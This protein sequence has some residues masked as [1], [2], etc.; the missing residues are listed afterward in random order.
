[1]N[2]FL[3]ALV[4][5][6]G[7]LFFSPQ[8]V[9]TGFNA[10]VAPSLS[11]TTNNGQS[12][13]VST[14]TVAVSLGSAPTVG[15]TIVVAAYQFSNSGPTCVD[16]AVPPNTYMAGSPGII[17]TG[18]LFGS[19]LT[20]YVSNTTTGFTVTCTGTNTDNKGIAVVEVVGPPS[21]SNQDG[22]VV[23]AHVASTN[24]CTAGLITAS[25]Q[26]D[27]LMVF[28]LTTSTATT[29]SPES[30]WSQIPGLATTG[31]SAMGGAYKITSATGTLTPQIG[32]SGSVNSNCSGIALK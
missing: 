11:V 20:A 7:V 18:T 3:L 13:Q 25:N 29:V 8:Y 30:G 31:A 10:G 23:S 17:N 6:W 24:S 27:L 15:H 12:G 1:M 9:S 22:S 16:N 21:S 19:V 28:L 26:P 32:F 5:L 2:L 4:H 14:L